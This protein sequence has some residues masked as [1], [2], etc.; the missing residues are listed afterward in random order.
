[1]M[2]MAIMADP[3]S[4]RAA[5]QSI[6]YTPGKHFSEND[7]YVTAH[8]VLAEALNN[9]VEHAYPARS[10]K[11]KK[12]S[13]T[14]R[15]NAEKA[16]KIDISL[17]FHPQQINVIIEDQG[18]PMS[19]SESLPYVS[20]SDCEV[21][22]LPEGQFGWYIIKTMAKDVIYSRKGGVNRL[23]FTVS[24]DTCIAAKECSWAQETANIRRKA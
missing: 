4:V 1:M 20:P 8:M 11:A 24:C 21:D 14:R 18:A 13:D 3:L 6:F 23:V 19:Q 10:E 22:D 12:R 5:L 7:L 9:I 16:E 17:S 2:K 15:N